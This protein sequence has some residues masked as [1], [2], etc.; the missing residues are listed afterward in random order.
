MR[1]VVVVSPRERD[2]DHV[3]LVEGVGGGNSRSEAKGEALVIVDNLELRSKNEGR[4]K[5]KSRAVR[6][7]H[8]FIHVQWSSTIRV[9]VDGGGGDDHE[10]GEGI[11]CTPNRDA[12]GQIRMGSAGG[13]IRCRMHVPL[14][15]CVDPLG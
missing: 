11:V 1:L 9:V 5:H 13:Q 14:W 12:S 3:R 10:H 4:W 15:R 2:V 6:C 7:C 8:L